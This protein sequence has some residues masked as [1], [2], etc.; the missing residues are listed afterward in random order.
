[1]VDPQTT[2]FW[3]ST[4]QSGL[5]DAEGLA[6]CWEGIPVEKRDAREHLDRRLARQAVQ[7]SRLT[8]WQAQQ[9]L[10]GRSNGFRVDRYLMLELLGHGGMGRVYLA[11]DTRLNRLVA[12]KILAPERMNNPRAIARFQREARVG[13]KLQH[14][15]LV[16]IYDFGESQGRYYLVMEYIEGKTI[17]ARIGEEGRLPAAEAARLTRQV[18]LGL[19]H[20]HRKGLIHRD[21][22]PYNVMVTHDGTA[23]LADLGLAI[24]MSEDGRVTREGATVGTFDYVAPE[25]ARQSQAADI[26]SDVYSLGCSIY[27]M[28]TGQ[29]PFPS[30]SLPEKLYSHQAIEPRSLLAL[31]PEAPPALAEVVARMMRKQPADRYQ[32][33]EEVVRALEPF[34]DGG[35]QPALE[36]RNAPTRGPEQTD[37]VVPATGSQIQTNSGT[38]D[39]ADAG[40]PAKGPSDVD[41]GQLAGS[42]ELS[43]LVD[44]GPEPPLTASLNRA[45][46]K[47]WF[48][49]AL[50]KTPSSATW[51]LPTSDPTPPPDPALLEQPPTYSWRRDRRVVVGGPAAMLAMA[52]VIATA[53]RHWP[54][55]EPIPRR[56]Q[57]DGVSSSSSSNPNPNLNPKSKPGPV[58]GKDGKEA[59]IVVIGSDGEETAQDD[60]SKALRLALGAQGTVELRNRE[61]MVIPIDGGS[62]TLRDK[63]TVRL[64]SAPGVEAVLKIDRKS[65]RN[66]PF[67]AAGP[68][69]DLEIEGLAFEVFDS[70]PASAQPAQA[71]VK[72][73]G[74]ARFDRCAWRTTAGGP[75]GSRA[76][77][78]Q[79]GTLTVAGCWFEGFDAAIEIEALAASRSTIRQTMIV[80]GAGRPTTEDALPNRVGWGVR[81]LFTSGAGAK[82]ELRLEHCTFAGAGFLRLAGVSD[83]APLSLIVHDCAVQSDS[84]IS[85]EPSPP[86][87]PLDASS[88]KWVG[89][90]NQLDVT[91]KS[92]IA[93]ATAKAPVV[94][95]LEGWMKLAVERDP[96]RKSI[97]FPLGQQTK[98]G[99]ATP[100][101]YSVDPTG[102]HRP[103]ADPAEVGPRP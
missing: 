1:M 63:G 10:A 45:K 23:K 31:A 15:N 51:I 60:L 73:L 88:L 83:Q 67:L 38:D 18:A 95:D 78:S 96:V 16:R 22:N 44:L 52:V 62:I 77:V 11:R 99:G 3:Q 36:A 26:R 86:D 19:D 69:V 72:A 90:G 42:G 68:S 20:A 79:G 48:G 89:E 55:T 35:A 33:P 40:R 103:G 97:L 84:L 14:E 12:L 74:R 53:Y 34:L 43:V 27:H 37:A 98:S 93:P 8:L 85:W 75:A 64:R 61:P 21:V 82:R 2:R 25:Q 81:F 56:S 87:V 94:E 57:G 71:V 5:V 17:G 100:Q 58:V 59:M 41:S 92:W 7:Q 54:N 101:S 80:P 6:A 65:L 91:G 9:L 13:A 50:G 29:V 32:T 66:D 76:L 28:I 30:P 70:G 49:G 46:P 102:A 39:G 47:P 4:L 24:D